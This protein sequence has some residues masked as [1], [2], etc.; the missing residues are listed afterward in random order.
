VSRGRWRW[1]ADENLHNAIYRALLRGA[2]N[3]DIT[4]VQDIP[5]LRGATD[6]A[7]LQ[8]ATET[9]RIIITHDVTTMVPVRSRLVAERG[10]CAPLLLVPSYLSVAAAAADVEL[11]DAFALDADWAA[12]L[13]YLP[14]R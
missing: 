2:S 11:L 13:L 12:G 4:R 8:W 9:G 14:L 6:D 10:E 7:L 3:I 1:I 5:H